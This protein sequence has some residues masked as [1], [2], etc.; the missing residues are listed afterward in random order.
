MNMSNHTF[1]VILKE[2]RFST[3]VTITRDRTSVK[4]PVHHEDAL[5]EK[6]VDFVRT[7]ED[8]V[9][10]ECGKSMRGIFTEDLSELVLQN[11]SRSEARSF[12]S[13]IVL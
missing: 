12:P 6:I 3:T 5:R 11:N 4:I 13:H 9:R 10:T 1:E 7:I 8:E 2:G